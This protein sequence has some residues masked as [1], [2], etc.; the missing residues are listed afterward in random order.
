[1]CRADNL[2]TNHPV[3]LS[4]NLV[5]LTSWNPLGYSRPVTGLL[6]LYVRGI[7]LG[8]HIKVDRPVELQHCRANSNQHMAAWKMKPCEE[9]SRSQRRLAVKTQRSLSSQNDHV[10]MGKEIIFRWVSVKDRERSKKP[11]KY[12]AKSADVAPFLLRSPKKWL[13]KGSSKLGVC[14]NVSAKSF[15]KPSRLQRI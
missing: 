7:P 4:R 13:W 15:Y 6:Y 9:N 8:K 11:S 12:H 5:T 3:P 10:K 2:T 1:M 14:E